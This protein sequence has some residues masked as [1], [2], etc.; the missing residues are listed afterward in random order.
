MAK[1]VLLAMSGGID[2]SVAAILLK[3]QGYA[4]TG[5][6]L[7]L[8]DSE[9]ARKDIA[10]AKIIAEAL[11]IDHTVLDWREFFKESVIHSFVSSYLNGQTPNPCIVCNKTIKFGKLFEYA[12]AENYDYIASGHYARIN[13][14]E[15]T[16]EY[17]LMK[18]KSEKKDQSYV[19]YS[20]TQEILAHTLFPLGNYEKDDIK[21]IAEQNNL[22]TAHKKD[23]QDICFIPDGDYVRFLTDEMNIKLKSGNF[24][25]I[26]HTT[27]GKHRDQICYTIGQRKGLGIALGKPVF[28]IEKDAQKNEVVL[29][30]NELL[31]NSSLYANNINWI[32]PSQTPTRCEA[33]IRYSQSTATVTI[34]YSSNKNIHV[35]FDKPQRAVTPGQSIVFYDKDTVLGGGII[36]ANDKEIVL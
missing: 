29:G 7:L 12:M 24:I 36:M 25:D 26:H 10:D 20:L 13:F 4:V 19:L 1:R 23:S 5:I 27:L 17:L 11:N 16:N 33:K 22:V 2:S 30:D 8:N 28:V 18:G 6:T 14:D 31:F 21:R 15:N 34:D 32:S 3:N 9:N 35:I